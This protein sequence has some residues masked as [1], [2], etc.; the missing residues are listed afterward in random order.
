MYNDYFG[1]RV[2]PFSATPDP[3][4]FYTTPVYREAFATLQ[5]GI[6][7]KKGFIVVTGEVGT[8]KTTLL[9]KLICS[10]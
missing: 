8:G 10:R 2:S 5:Y 9:R 3:Q 1:F 7:E 4:F 6:Q